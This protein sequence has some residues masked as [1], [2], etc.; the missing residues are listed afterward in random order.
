MTFARARKCID[1]RKGVSAWLVSE[2]RRN[3]VEVV[4]TLV[5]LV[6]CGV[7]EYRFSQTRD[8]YNLNGAV[9]V[10]IGL[11]FFTIWGTGLG[12]YWLLVGI[13]RAIT[14]RRRGSQRR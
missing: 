8:D 12:L 10:V 6:T 3:R 5:V 9:E 11:G 1:D 7:I 13:D 2:L 14:Q 4:W